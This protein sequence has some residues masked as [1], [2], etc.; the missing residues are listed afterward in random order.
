M[1]NASFWLPFKL[2]AKLTQIVL[3]AALQGKN[4]VRSALLRKLP[5]EPGEALSANWKP[6]K[7][8]VR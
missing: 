8:S 6:W 7:H 4:S 3:D 1:H 2:N 5:T